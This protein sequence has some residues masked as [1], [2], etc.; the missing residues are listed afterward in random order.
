VG[1]EQVA[2]MHLPTLLRHLLLASCVG[3]L[4]AV[5]RGVEQEEAGAA[6]GVWQPLGRVA[7]AQEV[8]VT[9]A[10]RLNADGV[11]ELRR[12]FLASRCPA[13]LRRMCLRMSGQRV[14]APAGGGVT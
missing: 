14:R 8:Q 12:R 4:W 1:D 3:V 10:L 13:R 9:L 7:A 6:R 5:P 2:R 11:R